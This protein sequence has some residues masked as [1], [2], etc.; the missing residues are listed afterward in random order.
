MKY[1]YRVIIYDI[2]GNFNEIASRV[3]TDD[4]PFVYISFE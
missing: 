2:I 3:I 1:I 4:Q